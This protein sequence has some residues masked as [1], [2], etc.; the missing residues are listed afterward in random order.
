[1][2]RKTLVASVLAVTIAVGSSAFAQP[3]AKG[4]KSSITDP[5]L[6]TGAVTR[7]TKSSSAEIKVGSA[8]VTFVL[9]LNGV[10]DSA[11]APVSS[12]NNTV[13]F[14]F[15]VNGATHNKDFFFD[16]TAGK[17]NNSQTKFP[18]SLSDAGTWGSSLSAGEP[19]EVRQVRVN[20]VGTGNI[21]GVDGLTTK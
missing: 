10:L 20:E 16:L 7:I 11:D 12:T 15:L 4:W 13:T 18:V 14:V 5:T 3:P 21:F 1:M 17:T 6:P 8:S 9:K 2:S 19:I